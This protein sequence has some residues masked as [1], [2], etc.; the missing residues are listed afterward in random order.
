MTVT[1]LGQSAADTME[2]E[3][4]HVRQDGAV[5]FAQIAVPPMCSFWVAR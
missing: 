5:L 1:R 3:T 4:L 2:L